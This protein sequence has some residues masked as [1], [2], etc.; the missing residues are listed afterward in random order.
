LNALHSSSRNIAEDVYIGVEDVDAN[1]QAI[2]PKFSKFVSRTA[3]DRLL[4]S[5][6]YPA[7]IV[8]TARKHQENKG[9]VFLICSVK[10]RLHVYESVYESVYD[11]MHDFMHD[12]HASHA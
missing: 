9:A 12:L 11:F 8:R 5:E 2:E 6:C 1:L 4:A 10:G 7:R 3:V